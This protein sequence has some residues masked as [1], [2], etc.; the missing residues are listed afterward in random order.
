MKKSV[1]LCTKILHQYLQNCDVKVVW[2]AG[3]YCRVLQSWIRAYTAEKNKQ[4]FAEYT[5]KSVNSFQDFTE[6]C[7]QTCH[8]GHAA[9]DWFLAVCNLFT[10]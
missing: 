2:N 3:Y 4:I 9:V 10:Q 1:R 7:I 5:W 6:L 8:F